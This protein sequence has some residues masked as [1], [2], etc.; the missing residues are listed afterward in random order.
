[1]SDFKSDLKEIILFSTIFISLHK[2][3]L[4][5]LTFFA[6][7]YCAW[8]LGF[9]FNY[10]EL[11]KLTSSQFQSYTPTYLVSTAPESKCLKKD[12]LGPNGKDQLNGTL[13]NSQGRW[14]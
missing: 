10:N 5:F 7:Q 3:F 9:V 14:N 6:Y 2:Y 12:H 4:L 8:F 13:A 1:M 11:I